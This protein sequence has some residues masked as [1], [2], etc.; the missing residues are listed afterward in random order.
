MKNISFN[1]DQGEVVG[2]IDKNGAGENT[3]LKI[4][5]RFTEPTEGATRWT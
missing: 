4:L 1:V 2:I 3:L 5:S